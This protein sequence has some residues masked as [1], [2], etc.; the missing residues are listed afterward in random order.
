MRLIL[1]LFPIVALSV[2]AAVLWAD[3]RPR[4]AGDGRTMSPIAAIARADSARLPKGS[5]LIEGCRSRLLAK[6]SVI[7]QVRQRIQLFDRQLFGSGIYLQQGGGPRPQFRFELDFQLENGSRTMVQCSDGRTLWLLEKNASGA[8]LRK[9]DLDRL[10]LAIQRFR[11]EIEN[12]EDRPTTDRQHDVAHGGLLRLI[13]DLRTN[14]QFQTIGQADIAG[15][16]VWVV[17]GIWRED[18]LQRLALQADEEG[19]WKQRDPAELGSHVPDDVLVYLD[20]D[21]L[22]PYRIQYRRL[23]RVA[24]D[25]PPQ[26]RSLVEMELFQVRFG[27]SI[28]PVQ[29]AKPV[30]ME[31]D[32]HTEPF[33]KRLA[34]EHEP[35]TEKRGAAEIE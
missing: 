13:E 2:I 19:K 29:F 11:P 22:F 35:A 21:E 6:S 27:A 20:R 17:Q 30:D 10:A 1:R 25:S 8:A 15:V 32:D 16:E 3:S 28:E 24:D 23:E 5:D 9:I 33:A 4:G 31:A 34:S 12:S 7:A 18:R 14:F 26:P